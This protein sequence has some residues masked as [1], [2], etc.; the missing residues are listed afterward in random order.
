MSSI[1]T[2]WLKIKKCGDKMMWYAP[3]I[4][5]TIAFDTYDSVM[6]CY[7]VVT[8]DGTTNFVKEED[9]E[10]MVIM[11]HE[12]YKRLTNSKIVGGQNVS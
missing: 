12:D 7:W 11:N 6:C 2:N 5:L 1:K 4:G 10:R 3:Y 9:C 8:Q